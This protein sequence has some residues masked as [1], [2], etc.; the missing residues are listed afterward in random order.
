MFWRSKPLRRNVGQSVAPNSSQL[1]P[2]DVTASS[3][4]FFFFFLTKAE[5]NA[6]PKQEVLTLSPVKKE[7]TKVDD[8][9]GRPGLTTKADD[10]SC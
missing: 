1:Y 7:T 2:A 4:S 9:V 3:G 8:Q 10:Q 6:L 5:L